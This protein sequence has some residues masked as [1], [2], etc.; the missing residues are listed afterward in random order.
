MAKENKL[1]AE[2]IG[3]IG[4]NK[5]L[6]TFKGVADILPDGDCWYLLH[7]AK[8]H[9][10]W[11][12]LMAVVEKIGKTMIPQ[13]WIGM[14]WDETVSYHIFK[15]GTGFTIGDNIVFISD[16]GVD[17]GMWDN[18]SKPP[19]ERTYLAVIEFIKWHNGKKGGKNIK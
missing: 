11:N 16:S 18:S 4:R 17:A 3:R 12:W 1:I 5:N 8:F 7:E 2:F 6:Y 14:K 13:E 19:I 15:I 9:C 10:D